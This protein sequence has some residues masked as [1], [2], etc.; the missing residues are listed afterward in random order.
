MRPP[1]MEQSGSATV[2]AVVVVPVLVLFAVLA[3]GFGRYEMLR[4]ELISD[5]RAGAEAASVVP[6]SEQS[7]VAAA[8][9]A[10]PGGLQ[11]GGMCESSRVLT[12]TTDFLPGGMVRA[13]V[14]CQVNLAD[15]GVPGLS[16]IE[17]LTVAQVAP[18]DGYRTVAS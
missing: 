12:D 4:A 14:S 8:A 10:G 17:R 15:L 5:A 3:I 13:S 18:I 9:V 6:S 1:K 16:G 2:E 7:A 11:Q